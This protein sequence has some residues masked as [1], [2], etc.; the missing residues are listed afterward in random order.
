MDECSLL[1]VLVH[2][3]ATLYDDFVYLL[4]LETALCSGLRA[5]GSCVSIRSVGC[6]LRDLVSGIQPSTAYHDVPS[7]EMST[8]LHVRGEEKG[9]ERLNVKCE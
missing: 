9:K 4:L 2:W 1:Y 8:E 6:G 5:V 7:I 3:I